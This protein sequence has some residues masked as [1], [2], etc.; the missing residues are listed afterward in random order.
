MAARRGRGGFRP[1]EDI[2]GDPEPGLQFTKASE[3]EGTD[4]DILMGY[5]VFLG[6]DPEN[7][8][9]IEDARSS[10]VGA[11]IRALMVSDEF[12]G[13]VLDNLSAGTALPHES[14]G[15]GPCQAQ[16]DW[17]FGL[18]RVP[19][20]AEAALR[21]PA[22][23]AAWFRTLTAVPGFPVAPP[24]DAPEAA[25]P[26][27]EPEEPELPV[28]TP[29]EAPARRQLAVPTL[30]LIT[31]EQ[32]AAGDTFRPGQTLQG[33]GWTIAPADIAQ[34]AV[35][36]D[37]TLLTYASYGLER[38]D[39]AGSFPQYKQADHCGFSFAARVPE[40]ARSGSGLLT[41]TV[42]ASNGQ[43][44]N[45]SVRLRPFDGTDRAPLTRSAPPAWP[46]RLMV[47]EASI[48]AGRTLW[49]RGWAVSVEPVGAV[50]ASFGAEDLGACHQG[51]SR[52][53]IAELHPAYANAA[54]SGW[55]LVRPIAADLPPGPAIL[56]IQAQDVAG[57][58]RHVI[59][60][61][62]IPPLAVSAAPPAARRATPALEAGCDGASLAA[63]GRL[64]VSG[65][66]RAAGPLPDI[67][68]ELDGAWLGDA[69]L[70]DVRHDL[71]L[72]PRP[73]AEPIHFG[74]TR[75][76]NRH[77]D[78]GGTLRLHLSAPSGATLL[79]QTPLAAEP[80]EIAERAAAA[81]AAAA[82]AQR[83]IAA[84]LR[85]EVDFP[86]HSGGVAREPLRGALTISG[87]TVAHA[88]VQSVAVF[89]DG[90][91]LG[92]AYLGMR[93]EDIAA[94]FPD[95]T[96]ALFA[97]Y[98]LVLPPGTL[99]EGRR[100]IRVVAQAAPM[101]G[102]TS[103]DPVTAEVAFDLPVLLYDALP[104]GGTLRTALPPA[105]VAFVRHLLARQP[106]APSFQIVLAGVPGAAP[107]LAALDSTLR[108][109]RAQL[110]EDWTAR[111]ILP[112][113]ATLKA[114]RALPC[115]QD[116]AGRIILEAAKTRAKAAPQ[117]S[118]KP[119][120][121]PPLTLLLR[122]GDR[123]SADALM[124]VSA[125]AAASREAEFFYADEVRHDP[126][127]ARR[128]PFFKPDWSPELLLGMNY[129]GRP[130]CAR[131]QLMDRAGLTPATLAEL[132]D[133]DAVLRLTEQATGIAH[134]A[135][136]LLDR[137]GASDSVEAE[138]AALRATIARRAIPAEILPGPAAATW[139]VRRLPQSAA[140]APRG[141]AKRAPGRVAGRVSII[142]PTCAVRQLIRAAIATI[143]ATTAPA[144]PGGVDAE[145]ILLDNTPP[146]D[147]ATRAW[148]RRN[149]ETVVAMP[150]PFNWSRFNNAGAAAATGEFLLFLNDDMEA[151]AP[152]WLEAMLE[153]A[154]RPEIG[155]V[156]ARLLY[157]DGKIQHGGQYLAGTHARHAFR[158]ADD[159]S[160][161][162]FGL[163]GV[164]R[165][166]ISVT[167]ACQMIRA[168]TFA[169][170]GGFDEAHDVVNNDLDFCLRAHQAGLAVI[171]T[172]HATLIHHEL[173]SRAT[174]EDTYD[175]ARFTT[176]WRARFL[177]GDPYRNPHLRPEGDHYGWERE[178]AMLVH[179]GRRGP[180]PD[181][182]R[183]ILAVKLDHIGDFLTALPALRSL[184]RHFP[185]AR[186]DLLAAA[187]TAELARS[188]PLIAE[189][190]IFDFFHARSGE[191]RLGVSDA[192]YAALAARLAPAQYDIAIDLR[193]HPDTR[194]VLPH[195][196]AALLAG[197]DHANRFP[198]LDLALEWEG[199]IRVAAKRAHISERLVQLVAATHAACIQEAAPPDPPPL[200]PSAVPALAR[201]PAGFLG[202]PIVCV[203]PG[204]GNAIRQWPATHFA[205]LIDLLAEAGLHAI[206]IGAPSETA[207]AEEV[208]AQV[209]ARAAVH[210]LVGAVK[211][212]D[213]PSVMRACVLFVGNNSGPQH[214]AASLGLPTLGI[215]SGVVDATEWAPLGTQ[216]A[217]IRRRMVCSPCYL[218]FAS[219]C[220]RNLA[221]LEGLRPRDVFEACKR[222]LVNI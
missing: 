21:H 158:F 31:L 222:L 186:I 37:G 100:H 141:R 64:R 168:D 197:Y 51:E 136:V 203:H 127:Q 178:P 164:A 210:S 219:D 195:T 101:P 41:V 34:I 148:L 70:G 102:D 185:A 161:G 77:P 75:L 205:G 85:L 159:A 6:R 20:A 201:L 104:P 82:M 22:G 38:P 44:D 99:A 217:A 150:G 73:D 26:L 9:V 111:V 33:S 117:R 78:Q 94:A 180:R 160:P 27:P 39:V 24:R 7:A 53:D 112:D 207:I 68:I 133:Y 165:E 29:Q 189:T 48:D 221:C 55:S 166:V 126:A 214:L 128:Q 174:L 122:P 132:S 199:D 12:R 23:W 43:S 138:A 187:A 11:F 74:F 87:W 172:P 206:L 135:R 125:R 91:P 194:E 92:S 13:S 110:L 193:M 5:R 220:P 81:A 35:H 54:Q 190:I 151:P 183:R 95:C 142:I 84:G 18:L 106:T 83:A 155:V 67:R 204:V 50:T 36:L 153:H 184:Q 59:T 14:A 124:E 196:G 144:I 46:I 86:A 130:W 134:I 213:L 191:G 56:R 167:G 49:L 154:A 1:G 147:R 15:D 118:P 182:V 79:L 10:P 131:P 173:A 149:A 113:A 90:A 62:E 163:A 200:P 121:Q 162:P 215:H 107:D 129:V 8:F 4:T 145:I 103:E 218:E 61:V 17:L 88:G 72:P 32:P 40:S 139:R 93:R 146:K 114:A 171:Y 109:L 57:Q 25:S 169:R 123:L 143:R 42:T 71:D 216:A 188:E 176:A 137:G 152:G 16:L 170:L 157:P 179:A 211:L 89:C 47:D 65:W 116:P 19:H 96:G 212:A 209:A 80:P 108:S 69:N 202:R 177:A 120:A 105:E 66:V 97:G 58:T 208:I 98:A 115:A 175:A 181:S 30:V 2:Q 192:N 198:F 140:A 60:P 156:G 45:K 52:P 63:D 119:P 28:S 3:N 76:I